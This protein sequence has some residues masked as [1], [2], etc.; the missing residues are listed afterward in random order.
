[1][2]MQNGGR[3][4]PGESALIYLFLGSGKI[5]HGINGS[6]PPD[7]GGGGEAVIICLA[8]TIEIDF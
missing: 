5:L 2:G 7:G 1:M 6:S 3:K 8:E 4:Y